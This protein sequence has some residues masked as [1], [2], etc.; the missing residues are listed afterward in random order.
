MEREKARQ[1]IERYRKGLCT[2]E[3]K[4]LVERWYESVALDEHGPD[5]FLAQLAEE[6]RETWDKLEQRYFR[7]TGARVLYR[8]I[9]VAAVVLLI[10]VAALYLRRSGELTPAA[11]ITPGYNQATLTLS[12]GR[13]IDLSSGQDGVIIGSEEITYADGTRI[14]SSEVSKSG[15]PE[16]NNTISTPNGG[17]YQVIL[18]DGTRV[19]LN[20]ASKLTYPS[21]FTGD[22]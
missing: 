18:P 9:A 19:W 22:S 5:I 4:V 8:Y 17:Q 16:G 21:R 15:R 13:S 20:A 2:P 14:F 3:E 11:D 1:L 12:D 6:R 7:T 10:A